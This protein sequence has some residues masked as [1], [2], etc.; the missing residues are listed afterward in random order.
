MALTKKFDFN[1][2]YALMILSTI[3]LIFSCATK[4]S[5]HIPEGQVYIIDVESK[6]DANLGSPIAVDIVSVYDD[7]IVNEFESIPASEW[8]IS[9]NEYEEK[10][11]DNIYIFDREFIPGEQVQVEYTTGVKKEPVTNLLFANYSTPGEHRVRVD[12]FKMLRII[13]EE[14]DFSVSKK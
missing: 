10:L 13:L 6:P 14:A 11:K 1:N 2:N 5:T 9:K 3:V 12:E 8:F 7:Q 4:E